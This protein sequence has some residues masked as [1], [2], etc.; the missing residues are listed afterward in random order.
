MTPHLQIRDMHLLH[1][2]GSDHHWG[3]PICL[4]MFIEANIL[5]NQNWQSQ[6]IDTACRILSN[7]QSSVSG[8][9][10][11]K[12]NSSNIDWTSYFSGTSDEFWESPF[13][14]WLLSPWYCNCTRALRYSW[15]RDKTSQNQLDNR[16]KWN[17]S[18]GSP[19]WSITW[20]TVVS[21]RHPLVLP[22]FW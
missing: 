14:L 13:L 2:T 17:V 22:G 8:H 11:R 16:H 19:Q 4:Q 9:Y 15:G 7:L 21:V 18:A 6:W 5:K 20:K 1:D 3:K 10:W 12:H